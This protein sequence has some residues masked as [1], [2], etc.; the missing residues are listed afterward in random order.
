M[1]PSNIARTLIGW[2]NEAEAVPHWHK[3]LAIV[4]A[5]TEAWE[6]LARNAER[7]GATAEALQTFDKALAL[8]PNRSYLHAQRAPEFVTR[9]ANR[10]DNEG[11][12]GGDR[13]Q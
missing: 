2:R 6:E 12:R 13:D 5:D 1:S 8:A 10:S 3:Y 9:F 4:P 7:R 11:L